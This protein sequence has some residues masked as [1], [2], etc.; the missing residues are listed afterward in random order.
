LFIAK[1][2]I[3]AYGVFGLKTILMENCNFYINT[4]TANRK[5]T[6]RTAQIMI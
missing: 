6:P 1:G 2:I 3:E 5:T 4:Y